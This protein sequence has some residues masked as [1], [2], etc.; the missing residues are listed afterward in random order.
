MKKI[1]MLSLMVGYAA[2]A[3]GQ[4]KGN[5]KLSGQVRDG[6]NGTPV[7]Y[8]TVALVDVETNKPV[9]GS[10]CDG[11]GKFSINK[12]TDGKYNV[13]VSFIGFEANTLSVTF[14]DK[15]NNLD[16]GIVKINAKAELLKEVTVE[17]QKTLIEERVDRTV[18]NAENDLTTKGGDATDV[19]KRVP[20][21]SVDLDGNV[22][23]R[24]NSNIR[25]LIN[26]RPSAITASSISDA[27]KQIPA[28]EIKS[29]E[30]ITSPSAKYDAEGSAGIINII[31]KKNVLQGATLSVNSSAGIRGSNLGLNGAFKKGKVGL[32][33]GGFGR[34]GYNVN[35]SYTNNQT[36]IDDSKTERLNTQYADTKSNYLFGR[37][38]LGFDYDINKN[39][40]INTS[41]QYGLRNN[42]SFQDN[43]TT[44]TFENGSLVNSSLRGVD[45]KNNSGS[46]DVNFG[47]T[48]LYEKPQRELSVLGL[49]SRNNRT[50]DFINSSL[51]E[52][53]MDI[54]SRLKNINES[55]NQEVTAQVDYQ[56]PFGKTQMLEV[57]AKQIMRTVSS[58][59][60]YYQATGSDGPYIA[61]DDA[62]LTNVFNYN[63]NISAGYLSYT[64]SFLTNYSL[65]AGARYEYTTIDANFSDENEVKIPS[66]GVLVPSINALRKLKNGNTIKVSY[67]RR[68]QRPSI[69]FL[70]PN[71]QQTNQLSQTIGNPQLD[72]EFTNNYELSYSSYIKGSSINVST[73]VR[74]TNNSIQSVR[75]VV[76]SDT[77]LT[78]YQNIGKEDA[79]GV[80]VFAN[81]NIGGKFSLNGGSD[82]Y[83]AVLN[84]NSPN[85]DFTASNEGWVISGRLFGNYTLPKNWALQFFGFYRGRQ[86]Q[87]QGTQGGFGI[88]SLGLN[89]SLG[90]DKRGSIGFGAE[91]FFT[92]A[93]KIKTELVSPSITQAS[94]NVMHNMNFKINF[95]YRIGKVSTDSGPRRK[96]KTVSND[97]LK[98]GGGGD[99]NSGGG[100]AAPQ[101]TRSGGGNFQAP[102][103]QKPTA[104]EKAPVDPSIPAANVEGTWKYTLDSPQGGNGTFILKKEDDKY[105]GTI[106][107]NRMPEPT[108]LSSVSVNGNQLTFTYQVN[109]GSNPV[110][111]E[112]VGT[113]TD[114][115]IKGDMVMGTYRTVP[116]KATKE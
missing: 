17:G 96:K 49:Y 83:Y 73:F 80:S 87:L 57:G 23:M 15:N 7:E 21:L 116:M 113:V 29:V 85:P 99:D 77:I 36:T 2:I 86:V 109:F 105:S 48:H 32:T 114:N 35:G 72:P 13:V 12:I 62:T 34:A 27:L 26:N 53:T 104:V 4:G 10:V 71:L 8:A 75:Q 112:V 40:Y 78:T 107:S 67:N 33:L 9:D 97:D 100:D 58:D 103:G 60:S 55:F 65:K 28:D 54:L 111:V 3:F 69:Q 25:V 79:Y 11:D 84:N 102:A 6:A 64:L 31:T 92:P 46:V 52:S 106:T 19:L 43:L 5:G 101:P 108:E 94:T 90:K 115:E 1:F 74:N 30:V 44:R 91:N 22:S 61:S 59:Y 37:Y 98:G 66:Y 51:D 14:D 24:G 110:T 93:F 70:N 63:Q 42:S 50:N 88:Y 68:I 81:V 39:N 89:K 76:G 41:V 16:L 20:M 18:Y 95:S 45:T 56:T 82:L 47:F 38:T